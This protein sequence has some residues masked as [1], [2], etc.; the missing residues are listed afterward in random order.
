M[1]KY[2]HPALY[3]WCDNLS[4][5]PQ[6]WWSWPYSSVLFHWH[7]CH[8]NRLTQKYMGKHLRALEEYNTGKQ[9]NHSAH[10]SWHVLY[11]GW[12]TTIKYFKNHQY[13]DFVYMY[14]LY[15]KYTL[16]YKYVNIKATYYWALWGEANTDR[17][18]VIS[19]SIHMLFKLQISLSDLFGAFNRLF[20]LYQGKVGIYI[21]FSLRLMRLFVLLYVCV[22]YDICNPQLQ[23]TATIFP[24]Y[25][26]FD[27]DCCKG[28]CRQR[29]Q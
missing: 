16:G 2:F 17:W 23:R 27:T 8:C 26:L 7:E 1:D 20:S 28:K 18:I 3:K 11:I 9:Q 24:S 10:I 19:S 29:V 21:S 14:Y 5:V 4:L 13:W 12:K 25:V 22:N 15:W 6:V